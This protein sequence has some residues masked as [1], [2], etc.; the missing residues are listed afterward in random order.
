METES[1]TQS[2]ISCWPVHPKLTFDPASLPAEK[3][4]AK[5]KRHPES[6]KPIAAWT[7]L[8]IQAV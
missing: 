4:A 7:N 5:E 6:L 8:H 3:P 1:P 2:W